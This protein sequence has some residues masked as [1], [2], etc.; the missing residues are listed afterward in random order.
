MDSYAHERTLTSVPH[1]AGTK[2]DKEQAEWVRDKLIEAGLDHVKT[3][4]YRVLLSYPS[5]EKG[6]VNEVSLLDERGQVRFATVG[7]QP[8]LGAPEESSD[9]VLPNYNAYSAGGV[10]QVFK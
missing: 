1:V 5:A 9:E 8:A 2:Q 4:P 6:V 3:V 10:V 7:K